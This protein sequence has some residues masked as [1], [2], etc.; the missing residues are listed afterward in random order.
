MS[1]KHGVIHY[2]LFIL[3]ILVKDVI[4]IEL[5][6]ENDLVPDHLDL[7]LSSHYAKNALT[8]IEAP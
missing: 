5:K 4:S 2:G 3:K 6:I 7:Q 1:H 8:D